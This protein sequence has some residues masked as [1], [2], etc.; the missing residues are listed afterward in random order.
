MTNIAFIGTSTCIPDVGSEVASLIIDGKHLVDTGWCSALAMR[1]HG[2]DPLA[3]ESVILTHLHQDHYIGLPHL[4]FFAGLRRRDDTG[5]KPLRIIGPRD[6][7]EEVVD[8]AL[9]FLQIPRFPQL[10]VDYTLVPLAAGDS[11]DLDGLHF[12]TCAAKH[13]GGSGD[14]EQALVFR[15]TDAAG[16]A[17]FA[18]TGDTSFHP[19]IA[20]LA[21]GLPLLIHD[22]CHTRPKDAAAIARAAGVG[23]LLL[24]HYP[25][26]KADQ[27]LAEATQ[28]F[29]HTFLAR[30]G[31]TTEV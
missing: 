12:D 2:F 8:S 20:N 5:A 18:F 1:E 4:L 3:I 31:E 6:H 26:A 14:S 13:A 27:I 24:I 25:K 19:P 10:R 23:R 15:A 11:F 16:Q 9:S 30:E 28:V 29:P 22:A 7:L 21:K 17:S